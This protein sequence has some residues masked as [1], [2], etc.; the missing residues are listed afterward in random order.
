[1]IK[2]YL[3]GFI[4]FGALML[5][6]TFAFVLFPSALTTKNPYTTNT[7]D[8]YTDDNG[9]FVFR[10]APFEPDGDYILGTDDSGRDVFSFIVYGTRL[11]LSVAISVTLLRFLIA[12]VFGIAAGYQRPISKIVIEQFNNVFNAIPPVLLCILVLNIPYFKTFSKSASTMVF[13]LVLT[14][15]EWARTGEVIRERVL[16]MRQKDF[17]KSEIAI[18][19]HPIQIV[20]GNIIPHLL[21]ELIIMFFM[22]I[23]RVLTV[24]MQ[25]GIFNIFIG[26]LRIVASS[27]Q[28]G[29]VGKATSY[30]PEWSSML[31]SAK[32]TIRSA[33]WIVFSSAAAFFFV[34]LGFNLLGEGL[35]R[36]LNKLNVMQFTK[37]ETTIGGIAF[38]LL[39]AVIVLPLMMTNASYNQFSMARA[40]EVSLDQTYAMPG[41]EGHRAYVIKRLEELGVDMA[42]GLESYAQA[43][44]TLDY[45]WI[46]DVKASIGSLDIEDIAL[47]AY[48]SFE[49][50]GYIYDARK[51]DISSLTSTDRAKI[52]NKFVLINPELYADGYWL[53]YAQQ[54]LNTTAAKGIIVLQDDVETSS[55]V[56]TATADGVIVSLPTRYEKNLLKERFYLKI[57]SMPEEST[58]TN[59]VGFIEG[60]PDVNEPEAI[61]L[62]FDLN[63]ESMEE[64]E[65]RFAFVMD[66]MDHLKRNEDR[67]TK[68]IL[69]VFWDGSELGDSG[70]K[71]IY[72]QKYYY[73]IKNT[74]FYLDLTRLDF[75]AGYSGQVSVDNHLISEVKPIA[76]NFT[77]LLVENI[78]DVHAEI[79]MFNARKDK[80]PFYYKW[81]IP[82]LYLKYD[83]RVEEESSTINASDLG[84]LLIESIIFEMY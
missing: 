7:L 66:L 50:E 11:T 26:N 4:V 15:V 62:G 27:D 61:I 20:F 34:V 38:V 41:D 67:L 36:Q 49:G 21:P 18:G 63:Y 73:A 39:I 53:N 51:M 60:N 55:K 19:K 24:L 12:L 75:S 80:E 59:V 64:G 17:I 74:E 13:V 58:I 6:V 77:N 48:Q 54:L 31:G 45:Y 22:E 65:R 37:R 71:G 52:N 2:K 78:E 57:D 28:G 33:P 35:R 84:N 32:N 83:T 3:N 8:G 30:E 9:A 14:M 43:Y 56:G 42:P 72:G 46:K 70:G 1:M 69:I 25:L 81:G 79:M 5:L 23:A 82:T 44:K 29:L 68:S 16:L 10:T 40:Q 47:Y 76:A